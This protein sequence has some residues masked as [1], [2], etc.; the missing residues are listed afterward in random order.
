MR[1]RR[2]IRYLNLLFVFFMLGA[3]GSL[4]A[5]DLLGVAYFNEV[6]YASPASC[7]VWVYGTSNTGASP[8]CSASSRLVFDMCTPSGKAWLG[9]ILTYNAQNKPMK[10]V[11]AGKCD[12]HHSTESVMYLRLNEGG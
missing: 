9:I 12:L 11:G 7:L 4:N 3:S 1:L 2:K 6:S 5:R 10:I 8:S